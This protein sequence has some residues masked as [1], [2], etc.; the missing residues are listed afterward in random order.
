[1]GQFAFL[2]VTRAH[3]IELLTDEIA[4]AT[5]QRAA[6]APQSPT[7]AALGRLIAVDR[8]QLRA[9]K[10]VNVDKSTGDDYI[11]LVPSDISHLT[12]TH[13]PQ[14]RYLDTQRKSRR[15]TRAATSR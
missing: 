12:M 9:A 14:E 2:R 7:A 5:Q 8:R 4:H 3:R 11:V 10:S 15:Q 13:L 6:L 1:M